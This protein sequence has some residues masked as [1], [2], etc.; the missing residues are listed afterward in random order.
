M[1]GS[2]YPPK[3]QLGGGGGWS[4]IKLELIGLA[5]LQKFGDQVIV[6]GSRLPSQGT[7][8]RWWGIGCGVLF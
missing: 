5:T 6:G 7:T 4:V 1:D 2:G 8:G 3:E